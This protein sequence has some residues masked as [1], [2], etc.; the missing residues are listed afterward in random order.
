[1]SIMITQAELEQNGF[2]QVYEPFY[3]NGVVNG[4]FEFINGRVIVGRT[5][6]ENYFQILQDG[7]ERE[8]VIGITNIDD[9]LEFCNKVNASS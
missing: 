1:M 3:E 7:D 6:K 4:D 8:P 5:N 2:T 9:L